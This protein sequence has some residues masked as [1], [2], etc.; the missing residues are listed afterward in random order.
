MRES[1]RPERDDGEWI[2]M[3]RKNAE[4]DDPVRE[5]EAAAAGGAAP[6]P[7]G[8]PRGRCRPV[9]PEL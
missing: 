1:G 4:G 9:R 3:K 5:A 2:G 6:A 7:G 8:H